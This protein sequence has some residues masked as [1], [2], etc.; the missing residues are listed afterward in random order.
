MEELNLPRDITLNGYDELS[1][2]YERIGEVLS[3]QGRPELSLMAYHTSFMIHPSRAVLERII[4]LAT[5]SGGL[6]RSMEKIK[7]VL[8]F[9]QIDPSVSLFEKS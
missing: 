3:D 8:G 1:D 7:D 2:L 5:I 4:F 6:E 9:H